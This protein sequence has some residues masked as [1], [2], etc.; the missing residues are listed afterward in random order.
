MEKKNVQL[1]SATPCIEIDLI[2]ATFLHN[3]S[4]ALLFALYK[5]SPPVPGW[6]Y[7]FAWMKNGGCCG[8]V[9]VRIF[10]TTAFAPGPGKMQVAHRAS[11]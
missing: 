11:N 1:V 8:F 7:A 4:C 2:S 9:A 10:F 5:N 3:S 6:S